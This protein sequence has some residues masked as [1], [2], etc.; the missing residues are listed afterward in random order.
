MATLLTKSPSPPPSRLPSLSIVALTPPP[1]LPCPPSQEAARTTAPA[2]RCPQLS[3]QRLR[4]QQLRS[5]HRPT[6]AMGRSGDGSG[7]TVRSSVTARLL[8]AGSGFASRSDDHRVATIA[9]GCLSGSAIYTLRMSVTARVLRAGS[10]LLDRQQHRHDALDRHR[11]PAA[12]GK[13]LRQPQ[14]CSSH[15]HHRGAAQAAAPSTRFT[16][17]SPHACCV[18]AAA[19]SAAMLLI[20][21]VMSSS[22]PG[23]SDAVHSSVATRLLRTGSGCVGSND[24]HRK[25]TAAMGCSSDGS[26]SD[27]PSTAPH[28]CCMRAAASSSTAALIACPLP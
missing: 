26:S 9:M 22:S 1:L 7:D 5:S 2:T 11:A 19:S 4:Q 24:A 23:S 15:A 28:D 25:P 13:R 17:A 12:C 14:R 3:L 21:A 6:T 27:V 16:R 20:A 8:R 18:R 10:D